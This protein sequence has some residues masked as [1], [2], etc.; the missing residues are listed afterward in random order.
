MYLA[1]ADLEAI[2]M[3]GH[4]VTGPRVSSGHWPVDVLIGHV[5]LWGSTCRH[6]GTAST[7][8]THAARLHGCVSSVAVAVLS[9]PIASNVALIAP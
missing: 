4:L 1:M 5:L 6:G 9:Y 7:I 8:D 3:M 2:D